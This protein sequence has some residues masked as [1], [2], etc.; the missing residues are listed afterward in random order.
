ML[1]GMGPTIKLFYERKLSEWLLAR[2]DQVKSQICRKEDDYIL[3]VNED[4]YI[5]HLV[6][7]CT[8]E[9][10][11]LNT[12]DA[13]VTQYEEEIQTEDYGRPVSIKC[14]IIKYHIPYEGDPKLLGMMANRMIMW[15]IEVSVEEGCVCF[16]IMDRDGNADRINHE[17][18][19]VMKNMQLQCGHVQTEVEKFNSRLK[20]RLRPLFD[21]RK[22]ELLRHRNIVAKLDVPFKKR[23]NAPETFAIPAPQKKQKIRFSEPKVHEAGFS[24]EPTL[25]ESAYNEILKILHAHGKRFEKLPSMYKGK[26]EEDIRDAFLVFLEESFEGSATGETFNKTGKT[27][28]LLRYDGDNAFIAE[29][30]FW[31]GPKGLG[32]TITQ[33]MG[34]LTWRDSKA[35]VMMFVNRKD[36]SA[37][38][39]SAKKAVPE[40]PNFDSVVDERE[41]SWFNYRFHLNGDPNRKLYLAVLLFHFPSLK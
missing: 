21:D 16:G 30:K 13:S 24:P 19:D 4:D 9:N 3:N 39:E 8:V 37:V 7:I 22:N 29:C 31:T 6:D 35:A 18:K 1:N 33:L 38:L 11:V 2:F 26:E 32:D 20:S 34:Y 5:A 10:L 25:D 14:N 36:F 17:S 15:S 12:E 41:D 40:H 28:I 27:D 23:D